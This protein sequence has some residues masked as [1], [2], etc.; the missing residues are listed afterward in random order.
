MNITFDNHLSIEECK[1]LL[2]KEFT[3]DELYSRVDINQYC[4]K[5]SEK[6]TFL[7]AKDDE[8]KCLGFIAYYINQ[9]YAFVFITRIAVSGHCRHQGIG[10]QMI[11]E[12]AK[13]YLDSFEAIELEVEKTNESARKFYQSMGFNL[14]EDRNTKLLLTKNLK[15]KQ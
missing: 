14:K 11:E 10:R 5:L 6:A 15:E 13:V 3:P 9:E 4:C 2:G 12:L 7:Q 8:G 1:H